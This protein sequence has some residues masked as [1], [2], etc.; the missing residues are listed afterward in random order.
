MFNSISVAA[1]KKKLTYTNITLA[2]QATA[3]VATVW[4]GD[5]N[6]P[7][8]VFCQGS[9]INLFAWDQT[10]L[11]K[12]LPDF[13]LLLFD[14]PGLTGASELTGGNDYSVPVQTEILNKLLIQLNVQPAAIIGYSLGGWM[15]LHYAANYPTNKL[16]LIATDAGGEA[17]RPAD[18][19]LQCWE[20]IDKAKTLKEKLAV[21]NMIFSHNIGWVQRILLAI[22]FQQAATIGRPAKAEVLDRQNDLYK[23]WYSGTTIANKITA[24]SLV[25]IPM[26]DEILA[27]ASGEA[28][29]QLLP[30][31]QVCRFNDAGHGLPYQY[32]QTVAAVIRG[33]LFP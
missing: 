4:L 25:L 33:Y 32:P 2:N 1:M 6:K 30:D 23:N 20:V 31:A 16:V 17:A 5:K 18:V 9:N 14:Y 13:S 21:F 29:A 24:G 15:A 26:Q 11:K 27:A 28:L 19:Y 12:L 3:K 8:L 7:C 10:L 22:R